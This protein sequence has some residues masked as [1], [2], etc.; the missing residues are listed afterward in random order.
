M[1]KTKVMDRWIHHLEGSVHP[2]MEA[3]LMHPMPLSNRAAFLVEEN[4]KVEKIMVM[5]RSLVRQGFCG[6]D[7]ASNTLVLEA[8]S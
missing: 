4:C 2:M 3:F 8:N 5:L 1:Q 6:T 7:Q